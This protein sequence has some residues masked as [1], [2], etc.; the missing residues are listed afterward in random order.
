MFKEFR[1]SENMDNV[2]SVRYFSPDRPTITKGLIVELSWKTIKFKQQMI[3]QS[4]KII[5][6][7][8]KVYMPRFCFG[9]INIQS[10]WLAWAAWEN[11][12]S[13]F[14]TKPIK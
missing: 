13:R 4:F 6:D 12:M 10:H 3:F 14:T 5:L 11:Y 8:K 9:L 2:L 7:F 1:C